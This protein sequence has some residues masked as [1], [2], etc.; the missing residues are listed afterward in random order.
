MIVISTHNK[1]TN[2]Q[3]LAVVRNWKDA[4]AWAERVGI[5]PHIP[6]N[7]TLEKFVHSAAQQLN[8]PEHTVTVAEHPETHDLWDIAK[9]MRP[10]SGAKREPLSKSVSPTSDEDAKARDEIIVQMGG[11]KRH[12]EL[13][14]LA[15]LAERLPTLTLR[16]PSD[17]PIAD[18]VS[19]IRAQAPEAAGATDQDIANLISHGFERH[20]GTRST[21]LYIPKS[22]EK[23]RH[24][25]NTNDVS[26]KNTS[27]DDL[28]SDYKS[29][30]H[31]FLSALA[32]YA[33]NRL[34]RKA[35]YAT[36]EGAQQEDLKFMATGAKDMHPAMLQ[37][38][39][40]A[41]LSN[42]DVLSGALQN[43]REHE[44]FITRNFPESI[45]TIDG[46]PHVAVS[47]ALTVPQ[48]GEDYAIS[49]YA[50][51]PN[52][53]LFGS[54]TFRY[55]V[56]M[57]HIWNHYDLH[58]V[59]ATSAYG[60]EDEVLV[61]KWHPRIPASESEVRHIVPRGIFSTQFEV[62]PAKRVVHK[63]MT[64][65][66]LDEVPGED[67]HSVLRDTHDYNTHQMNRDA[68][69]RLFGA[70]NLTGDHVLSLATMQAPKHMPL[71]DYEDVWNN[72]KLTDDHRREFAA[73]A[74]GQYA[75]TI[76]HTGVIRDVASVLAHT[77]HLLTD[78]QKSQFASDVLKAPAQTMSHPHL[79]DREK[80]NLEPSHIALAKLF[81]KNVPD[82]DKHLRLHGSSA[83]EVSN[84]HLPDIAYAGANRIS[85]F[86]KG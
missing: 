52:N 40:A 14:A 44:Q 64:N 83:E 10:S 31:S 19:E 26:E 61:D 54:N 34:V 24:H 16:K 71:F 69:S 60:S 28:L 82:A 42:P 6:H 67:I 56:P 7:I 43:Q 13:K 45:R 37:R 20:P 32:K 62:P 84:R 9:L 46:V 73:H 72:S 8:S 66:S 25:I 11:T 86:L 36:P 39:H 30:P 5:E 17:T 4:L 68:I 51:V 15:N 85:K 59:G 23:V 76:S 12:E 80:L 2:R 22:R 81:V 29:Q 1:H 79:T 77:P 53:S 74:M 41:L 55:W 48:H 78:E 18:M 70:K 47:R 27:W 57:N 21:T 65:Q 58:R 3:R 50:D 33:V 38:I 63:A 49:S 75:E 35:Q